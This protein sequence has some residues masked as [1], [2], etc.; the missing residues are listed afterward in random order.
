[1]RFVLPPINVRDIE[2]FVP[3]RCEK[4]SH[5][6]KIG[7]SFIKRLEPQFTLNAKNRPELI[8][9]APDYFKVQSF[10]G[11]LQEIDLADSVC[12]QHVRERL[13]MHLK[14]FDFPAVPFHAVTGYH[15]L[16]WHEQRA[17]A[18]KRVPSELVRASRSA[19]GFA[20]NRSSDDTGFSFA[21]FLRHLLQLR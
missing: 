19:D 5:F 21:Q 18:A 11:S 9:T 12:L 1:R 2:H 16:A 6:V 10:Q 3:I 15:A 7:F 14:R 8:A 20:Q 17:S 13:T 4:T